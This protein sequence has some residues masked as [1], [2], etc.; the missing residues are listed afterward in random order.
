MAAK[1]VPFMLAAAAGVISIQYTLG[2][3]LEKRAREREAQ[4]RYSSTSDLGKSF[5]IPNPEVKPE[6]QQISLKHQQ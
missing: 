1:L 5:L 3:E 2:P 4:A 6:Y